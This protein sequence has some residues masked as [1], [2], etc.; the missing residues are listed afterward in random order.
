MSP[1]LSILMLVWN[2]AEYVVRALDSIPRRD[3]IEVLVDDN[4]STDGSLALVTQYKEEH[5][6]LNMIVFAR[7]VETG[8]S[9]SLNRL[10]DLANGEYYHTLDSD[11][12]LYTDKYNLVVDML[13]GEYDAYFINLKTNNGDVLVVDH[14]R[15]AY[16]VANTTRLVRKSFVDGLRHREDKTYDADWWFNQDFLARRPKCKYTGITAYHYNYPREGSAMDLHFKSG[17]H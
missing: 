5:P 3:D 2:T 1:K 12:Y 11:D 15:S 9:F 17:G 6:E 7:D 4:A 8:F 14:S 10:M 13:D 16:P